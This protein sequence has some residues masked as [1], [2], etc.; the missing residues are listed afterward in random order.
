M[1]LRPAPVL[2]VLLAIGGLALGL[3]GTERVAIAQNPEESPVIDH[4]VL[5]NEGNE[6]NLAD[7]RGTA[8]LI[9]NTASECGL[10]PQLETLEFLYQRYRDRGFAV[11]AFPSNDYGGQEPGT[12]EEIEQFYCGGPYNVT[13]PIFDKIHTKGD[14]IAPLYRT[15]T[16]ETPED[17]RGEITWNFNK[18]LVDAEG[19]VVARFGARVDPMDESVLNAVEAVLPN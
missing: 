4:T 3:L 11:L 17:I 1:R 5:D 19:R 2:I 16:E 10:T 7:Y 14:E 8:L 18:F 6:V 9:V 13:F 15:L 12:N